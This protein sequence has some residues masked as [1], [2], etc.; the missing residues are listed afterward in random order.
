MTE[1][2]VPS[3]KAYHDLTEVSELEYLRRRVKQLEAEVSDL[4][5]KLYPDRMGGC[6]S[7]DE[8]DKANTWR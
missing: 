6:F 2:F 8:I 5:W 3:L 7:Q 4:G 1:K